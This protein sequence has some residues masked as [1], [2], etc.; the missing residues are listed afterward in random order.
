MTRLMK[1]DSYNSIVY[2]LHRVNPE[3]AGVFNLF[4]ADG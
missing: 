4:D 2:T 3:A 1:S